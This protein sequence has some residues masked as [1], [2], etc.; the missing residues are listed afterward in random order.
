MIRIYKDEAGENK[1][2][3][4]ELGDLRMISVDVFAEAPPPQGAELL[5][6]GK[7]KLYIAAEEAPEGKLEYV[8]YDNGVKQ[9]L[10]SI[11]YIGRLSADEALAYL[12]EVARRI[13]GRR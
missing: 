5:A 10:I 6:V 9:Q 11:R 8:Y 12:G 13:T 4:I 7:Y 2:R 1:A 3:I